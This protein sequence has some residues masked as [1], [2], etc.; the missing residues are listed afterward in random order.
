MEREQKITENRFSTLFISD[1]NSEI[2]GE[3]TNTNGNGSLEKKKSKGKINT[4][5]Y[6]NKYC[7]FLDVADGRTT[8][9]DS[10][11]NEFVNTMASLPDDLKSM[12]PLIQSISFKFSVQVTLL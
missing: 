2:K 10:K 6:I 11:M 9:N 12:F 7:I 3:V 5:F 4:F 1:K 8:I